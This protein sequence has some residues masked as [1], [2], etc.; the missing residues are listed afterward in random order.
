[1][2][3]SDDKADTKSR[4]KSMPKTRRKTASPRRK[5]RTEHEEQS[6][7]IAWALVAE[8]MQSDPVKRAALR[9]L[10]AIPNGF[11]RSPA[12]RSKAK[13]EGVKSGI[14]D[15]Q[16]PAPELNGSVRSSGAYHGLYIEMKRRGEKLREN[17]SEFMDYLDAVHYRNALCFTWQAAARVIVEHLDLTKYPAIEGDPGEDDS[18]YVANLLSTAREIDLVRNPPK[19]KPI[20]VKRKARPRKSK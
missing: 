13:R 8:E 2:T 12:A 3:I 10:H 7:V 15:L 17:Q 14:L 4:P 11:Y 1:M 18:D 16:I 19:P 6:V 5:L 20:K 9:W